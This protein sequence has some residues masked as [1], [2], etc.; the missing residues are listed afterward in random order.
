MSSNRVHESTFGIN[1]LQMFDLDSI[2]R[3]QDS[4]SNAV[5]VA[6][7]MTH[8]DG[9]PIT[10]PSNFCRLCSLIRKTEAGLSYCIRCNAYSS[11]SDNGPFVH[12]CSSG[13]LLGGGVSLHARGSRI[14]S[15]VICQVKDRDSNPEESLAFAKSVGADL[16]AYE[17]AL[18]EVS[19]MSFEHFDSILKVLHLFA[20]QIS[21]LADQRYGLTQTD[22]LLRRSNYELEQKVADR[23]RELEDALAQLEFS[24]N[25]MTQSE[26]LTA[27][28]NLVTGIAHEINTPLGICVTA[29]TQMEY[30][31]K[32]IAEYNPDTDPKG[33]RQ[34][35]DLKDIQTC[36]ELI[37]LNVTRSAELVSRFKLIADDKNSPVASEFLLQ[38]CIRD[39]F[40]SFTGDFLNQGVE[41]QLNATED[42]ILSGDR[43]Q[44]V[45]LFTHLIN[46]SLHHG[47]LDRP[48]MKNRIT[49]TYEVREYRGSVSYLQIS[50]E[51]NG[52]GIPEVLRH[53]IF[54]PF[55]TSKRQHDGSGLGLHYVNQIMAKNIRGT[56]DLDPLHSPGARF[57]ITAPFIREQT[58]EL[59]YDEN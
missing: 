43:S 6:S 52:Q 44:W 9:R 3:I 34:A 59:I 38:K 54:E 23:T 1:F 39:T 28:T 31:I 10:K 26:K 41:W 35:E 36:A 57:I 17:E 53:R 16:A 33:D 14:A 5:G 51:D 45:Q 42:V 37:R 4:F 18:G 32:R 15:W 24:H 29:T 12:R 25:L 55:V 30:L 50:Y 58:G 46:N 27:L 11:S 8:P 20:D 19:E 7:I 47:F 2:Q 13:L 56:I 21:I 22:L 49:V 48:N 40:M